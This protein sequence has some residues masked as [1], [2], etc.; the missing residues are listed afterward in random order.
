M[1]WMCETEECLV[2]Q[3]LLDNLVQSQNYLDWTPGN[4]SQFWGKT[5]Q[6]GQNGRLGTDSTLVSKLYLDK[7]VKSVFTKFL[8]DQIF[9]EK[10]FYLFL[11]D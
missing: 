7:Q 3:N 9:I 8:P 4:Y 1:E 10:L 5:L 2:D 6:E 11:M